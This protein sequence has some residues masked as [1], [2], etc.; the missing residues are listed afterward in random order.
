MMVYK[1]SSISAF[2]LMLALFAGAASATPSVTLLS[3]TNA[4]AVHTAYPT[5]TFQVDGISTPATCLVAVYNSASSGHGSEFLHVQTVAYDGVSPTVSMHSTRKFAQGTGY[6]WLAQCS[7]NN[8]PVQSQSIYSFN[9]AITTTPPTVAITTPAQSGVSSPITLTWT[10]NT[11]SPLI[12]CSVYM[13]NLNPSSKLG[14]SMVQAP[15]AFSYTLPAPLADGTYLPYVYCKDTEGIYTP[16]YTVRAKYLTVDT[17]APTMHFEGVPSAWTSAPAA[18]YTVCDEA[19]CVQWDDYFGELAEPEPFPEL[20]ALWYPPFKTLA[21]SSDPGSCSTD[22]S[23]YTGNASPVISSHAWLCA[24][25]VDKAGNFAFSAP[26]EIK[27]DTGAPTVTIVDQGTA[28]AQT[29]SM[30]ANAFDAYTGATLSMGITTGSACDNSL[31]FVPYAPLYFTSEADNGKSVCYK[32]VDGVGNTVYILSNAIAGIDTTAP[33]VTVPSDI[34]T[35]AT[36]ADGAS[37]TY[38]ASATD[39][40]SGILHPDCAP[41][42]GSLFAVG[43]TAVTCSATDE[44]G[45]TGTASFNVIVTPMPLPPIVPVINKVKPKPLPVA[46]GVAADPVVAETTKPAVAAEVAADPVAEAAVPA[47]AETPAVETAKPVA[48]EVAADPVVAETTVPA[49]VETPAVETAKPVAIE[50]AVEAA[51]AT[52]AAA[53]EA[54]PV[55]A[56]KPAVEAADSIVKESACPTDAKATIGTTAKGMGAST[57]APAKCKLAPEKDAASKAVAPAAKKLPSKASV[58]PKQ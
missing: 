44:A 13:N 27:V 16:F 22:V 41:L 33:A 29:K 5:F 18:I 3:P 21:Y 50:T 34:T 12:N 47:A 7:N 1:N 20:L 46:T 10:A 9:V 2:V 28:P 30:F 42:S 55:A 43:T 23:L 49:A 57:K 17:T 15:G 45:N 56:T 32:A 25:V 8:V 19:N 54:T 51:D 4:S 35:A 48:T 38:E 36:G 52:V 14:A 24:Y 37:V 40:V 58:A 53:E 11:I 31:S 6:R 26:V 39:T